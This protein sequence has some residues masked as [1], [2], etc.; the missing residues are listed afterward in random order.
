MSASRRAEDTSQDVGR[1]LRSARVGAGRTLAELAKRTALSEGFLSKLER[2]QATSSIANLIRITEVLGLGMHELFVPDATPAQTT[3]VV[4]RAADAMMAEVKTTG[5][6]WRPLAGGS[7]LDRMEVF[8][9]IFPRR[10]R[11]KLMVSHAGQEHCYVL[12]GEIL[13][14]VGGAKHRL[15]AGDGIFIDSEQPHRAQNAGSVEAHGLM[16]VTK[17]AETSQTLDWW[18]PPTTQKADVT[19]NA[20]RPPQREETS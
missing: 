18:R 13:F 5:Y 9:L 3:A 7:P 16:V 14:Y 6:R 20:I 15:R 8:H 1:R 17:A 4:H 19:A 12:S 10:E 11:M 2:G